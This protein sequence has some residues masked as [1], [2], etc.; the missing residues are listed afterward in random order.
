MKKFLGWLLAV[1]AALVLIGFALA[2]R[3]FVNVSFDPLSTQSP[4]FAI[5]LPLWIVLF[6][7]IFIGLVVGWVAAWINQ[8]KWRKAAHAARTRL[9]DEIT[10][11]SAMEKRLNQVDVHGKT[12][13]S[14]AKSLA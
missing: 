6:S 7:G 4:W 14:S 8:G 10:R 9:D 3:S 2:N 11:K 12:I 5:D 1:P 13:T